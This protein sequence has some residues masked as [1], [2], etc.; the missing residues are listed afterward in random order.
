[1]LYIYIAIEN[2]QI[3]MVKTFEWWVEYEGD[4]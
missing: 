3:R 4:V 2:K 1:M